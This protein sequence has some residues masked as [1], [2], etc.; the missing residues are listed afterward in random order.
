VNDLAERRRAKKRRRRLLYNRCGDGSGGTLESLG[1]S[2]RHDR[3]TGTDG[4]V[5]R[6]RQT[7]RRY[8]SV[9]A[10]A[11]VVPGL[12]DIIRQSS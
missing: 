4:Q 10:I 8:S 3:G 6:H 5:H 7:F 11:V 12:I 9:V 1:G 2:D